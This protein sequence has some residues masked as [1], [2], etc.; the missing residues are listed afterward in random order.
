PILTPV[1]KGGFNLG[2]EFRGG[3]EFTVSNVKTPDPG[4]GEKAV[5]DVV[6]GAIPRVANVARNTL[7]IQTDQLTDD[8][9]NRIK[10]GLTT[11]YGV[12]DNEVTSN[13]VVPTGGTGVTR[14]A[15]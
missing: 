4:L 12:T 8:E 15:L 6:S 2:I 7:R 13:F 9:T 3:S 1:L 10:E 11:A 5:H 14:Q